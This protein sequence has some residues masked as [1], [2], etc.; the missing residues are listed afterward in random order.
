M[1]CGAAWES[2]LRLQTADTSEK[3]RSLRRKCPRRI[4]ES[5][6]LLVLAVGCLFACVT[7]RPAVAQTSS[8][9]AAALAEDSN[10]SLSAAVERNRELESIVRDALFAPVDEQE[11]SIVQAIQALLQ[12]PSESLVEYRGSL[13]H[14]D[15]LAE[16]LLETASPSLVAAYQRKVQV[17]A[18]EA[19]A[20][21][22]LTNDVTALE[23]LSQQYPHTSAAAEANALRVALLLDRGQ[24]DVVSMLLEGQRLSERMSREL[25]QRLK[26][27]G[28]PVETRLRSNGKEG[29]GAGTGN[30][31]DS[32]V[33]GNPVFPVPTPEWSIDMP[34]SDALKTA[35]NRGSRDLRENGLTVFSPWKL[36]FADELVIGVN[37][38]G[39]EARL[40]ETGELVWQRPFEH[41]TS[42]S[43]RLVA[44]SAERTSGW[45]AIYHAMHRL[46]G[47]SLYA[48]ALLTEDRVF[49]VEPRF[50]SN[51]QTMTGSDRHLSESNQRVVCLNL[52]TGELQWERAFDGDQLAELCSVPVLHHG[53]LLVT[54]E[55]RAD[56]Q[57]CLFQLD[58]ATGELRQVIPFA[59]SAKPIEART[60]A[61]RDV[62]RMGVACPI[63]VSGTTAICSTG[64]GVVAAIDLFERRV[65]WVHRFPRSDIPDSGKEQMALDARISG[66]Q[67]WHGWQ[68]A[69]FESLGDALVVT[70]PEL[71]RLTVL[72]RATGIERWA[73]PRNAGLLIALADA[74]WGV[75][76]IG[77]DAATAYDAQSGHQKWTV[78]L[79]FP[80]GTGVHL[81]GILLIPD[82]RHGWTAIDLKT[83]KSENSQRNLLPT[84]APVSIVDILEPRNVATDGENFFQVTPRGIQRL[85]QRASEQPSG[86]TAEVASAILRDPG[87]VNL[88]AAIRQRIHAGAEQF[89]GQDLL[90]VQEQIKRVSGSDVS[91][92]QLREA[93][94][95]VESLSAAALPNLF[96]A[97]FSRASQHADFKVIHSLLSDHFTV[98]LSEQYVKDRLRRFR[99]GP[100]VQQELVELH[101]R[102][103]KQERQ[104]LSETIRRVLD[105]RLI[106]GPHE[107][108]FWKSVFRFTPWESVWR[109]LAH[110]SDDTSH[111]DLGE[112]QAAFQQAAKPLI[113]LPLGD[114]ATGT[115]AWPD[116]PPRVSQRGR[117][118]G[119]LLFDPVP[120]QR[121]D[122]SPAYDLNLDIEYPGFRA[123]RFSSAAWERP[124]YGYLPRTNRTLRYHRELT[125]AWQSG[126][127]VIV[128]VGSE[129]Y[130]FRPF[131]AEGHPSAQLLWPPRGASIDTLGNRSNTRMS[132]QLQAEPPRPGFARRPP[133]RIDE[134]GH[135]VTSV[136]PVRAGYFG[137]Q[138]K[139][140]FVVCETDTG[141]ER[142]RR[143]QLPQRAICLGDEL[144]VVI[145][146]PHAQSADVY[147]SLDGA[148]IRTH[149][150]EHDP[151]SHLF[152][153]GVHALIA[154]GPQA[155][156]P[157]TPAESAELILKWCN[158]SS[159]TTTWQRSW[160][161]GAIPLEID[162]RWTGVLR[163]DQTLEIL[164]TATGHT[165]ATHR[166]KLDGKA[167]QLLCHAG[168]DDLLIA[169]G[170]QVADERLLN[171]TQRSQGYRRS[172][173]SGM[174]LNVSRADGTLNWQTPLSSA[175]IP[176]VQPVDLPV[177][178]AAGAR[179][180][181]PMMD[182]PSPGSRIR[183]FS[184]RT[185]EQLFQSES[186]NP[187]AIYGVSGYLPSG[188]V[189]LTTQ[190]A[191]VDIDYHTPD[192][193]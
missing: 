188:R 148:R 156:E 68:H 170:T 67:F 43:L 20:Q 26:E 112:R 78:P 140:M 117:G 87:Q 162:R 72:E 8:P 174:L 133:R 181:D 158:L 114:T 89:P 46:Y 123:V 176:H 91:R 169:I 82:G 52:A 66:F 164:E 110:A 50:D 70:S 80:T 187:T 107:S 152:Y 103:P 175:V 118:A 193:P 71:D 10:F 7:C 122:G 30:T 42:R 191:I 131:T 142:W 40:R 141:R 160:D 138:Q 135:N 17:E 105:S 177:F 48:A 6:R 63:H 92:A 56:R 101:S 137:F 109:S 192:Q 94:L 61:E 35:L 2:D 154:L 95:N 104:E 31:G 129:V 38:F 73:V 166:L 173:L 99:V 44:R 11:Q 183:L 139:G 116:G 185:G 59:K 22:R 33:A 24:V 127:V 167:S 147:S 189:T 23:R 96:R 128:Q 74:Q 126:E 75:V 143:Y 16:V 5:I 136:G 88:S 12:S 182:D 150:L 171:A 98:E 130:G 83:G 13:L 69:Q 41:P 186:L 34:L 53:S 49:A 157:T 64:A 25:R 27:L 15:R 55:R 106:D 115:F 93:F 4:V 37:L 21:A 134:F 151:A 54:A 111:A 120:L 149:Q 65:L 29:H 132:F 45:E 58:P 180:N 184:R 178:V 19:W 100:W 36:Q 102:L 179:L 39:R 79:N 76:V 113:F 161:P 97:V 60:N 14:P 165:V 28:E 90:I 108:E 145:L 1:S 146:D 81:H 172:I 47:E 84:I 190:T 9:Q 86:E 62:R 124:W 168:A 155:T 144:H 85:H 18:N 119:S 125:R 121:I 3:T 32:P 51:P 57:L 77:E 163:A 153:S 159:G